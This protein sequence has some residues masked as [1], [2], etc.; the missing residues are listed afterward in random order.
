MILSKL[1]LNLIAAVPK[2]SKWTLRT[3]Y[4]KNNPAFNERAKLS[5]ITK[6][7]LVKS[8][9]IF[10]F[11]VVSDLSKGVGRSTVWVQFDN[12]KFLD[13]INTKLKK[14]IGDMPCRVY[15]G[16]KAFVYWGGK[17]NSEK[18]GYNLLPH[19]DTAAPDIRDPKRK[20]YICKHIARV[21]LDY[22]RRALWEVA[23]QAGYTIPKQKPKSKLKGK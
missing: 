8:K 13:N 3:L 16:C 1:P 14:P 10:R 22:R 21:F 19:E 6:V 18:R 7:E 17:Y 2:V 12:D 20:N 23:V 15:C 5:K 4:V 9:R 11:K